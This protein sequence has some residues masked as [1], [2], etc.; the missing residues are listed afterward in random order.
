LAGRV[1]GL[2]ENSVYLADAL[3]KIRV[4]VSGSTGTT[5]NIGDLVV[6]RGRVEREGFFA[7]SIVSHEV[8]PEPRGNGEFA[9]FRWQGQG[10]RLVRRAKLMT[11]IRRWFDTEGFIEVHT[12]TL[13]ETPGLDSGVDAISAEGGYLVTSPELA[14]KRLLV[15]GMP[16]IYQLAVCFRRDEH[17]PIHQREFTMLEWYRAFCD[18]PQVLADTETLIVAL[19]EQLGMSESLVVR[20][21]RISLKRPF[22]RISVDDAFRRYAGVDDVSLLAE[23]DPSKY[24]ELLVSHVEPALAKLD[25]PVFLTRYPASQAALSRRC[26][27]DPRFAERAELYVAGIELCNAYGE[28][29][30]PEEQR[31]RFEEEVASRRAQGQPEYPLDERFLGALF[32]GMPQSAGNALGLDRLMMLLL[33][34]PSIAETLAFPQ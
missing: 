19:A 14:M 6:L 1:E 3:A 32:E 18:L 15:G 11:A 22:L 7:D 27:D 13:L 17:G 23:R 29:S 28:L 16:R 4:T 20:G 30:S 2:E 26:S 34:Q 21:R 8:F 10:E 9:R 25:Q 5:L 31:R 12:P 24:F 33:E